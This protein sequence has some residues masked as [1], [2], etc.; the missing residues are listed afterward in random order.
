MK[1]VFA[2]MFAMLSMLSTYQSEA[3]SKTQSVIVPPGTD[4]ITLGAQS[5]GAIKCQAGQLV[6]VKTDGNWSYGGTTSVTADGEPA[7]KQELL[8]PA[9]N[10]A[11]A[12]ALI[13]VFVPDAYSQFVTDLTTAADQPNIDRFI[14]LMPRSILL[15]SHW[16]GMAPNDGYLIFLMNDQVYRSGYHD[17]S[18]SI[19]VH[20][21]FPSK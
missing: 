11:P 3:Q 5:V 15:G 10:A 8:P 6:E 18:G 13:G 20:V 7:W 12:G 16:K 17:N 21:T 1:K 4:P 2:A 9:S 14:R 19:N